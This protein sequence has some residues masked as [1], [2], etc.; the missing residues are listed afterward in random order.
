MRILLIITCL[1]FVTACTR[2]NKET[3]TTGEELKPGKSEIPEGVIIQPQ[4]ETDTIKGSPKAYAVGKIGGA[5]FTVNYYSP[6]TRGRMIWGGLVAYDNVWVTGA[7]KATSIEFDK[8]I[9]IGGTMVPSGKYAFFTIP[10]KNLWTIIINKNWNQHL[11]DDYS[12][13][14]DVVRLAVAPEVEELPQER[15]RYVIKGDGD[16]AGEIMLYW[17]KLEVSLPFEIVN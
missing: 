15:L 2:S 4:T 10:G 6:A 11:A 16:K 7:H 12:Q 13:A 14:E 1:A 5:N 9:K 8:D 3:A 17:E